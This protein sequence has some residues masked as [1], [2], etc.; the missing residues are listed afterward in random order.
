[1][2]RIHVVS[3]SPADETAAVGGFEWRYALSDA[4]TFLREMLQKEEGHHNLA[5][6]H[7]DVPEGLD[8]DGITDW[9]DARLELIEPPG[10]FGAA[11]T[12]GRER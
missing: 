6:V 8:A 7:L 11:A 3:F 5:L 2:R 12:S 10:N 9:I 1:M 4:V